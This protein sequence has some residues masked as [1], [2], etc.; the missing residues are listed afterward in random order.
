V[1]RIESEYT[2]W[3]TPARYSGAFFLW[4]SSNLADGTV[5]GAGVGAGVSTCNRAHFPP[6]RPPCIAQEEMQDDRGTHVALG[7]A[8]AI[9]GT[10]N[11]GWQ[12]HCTGTVRARRSRVKDDVSDAKNCTFY[13]R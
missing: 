3:G 13:L 10:L 7:G 8:R 11:H 5:V 6:P 1:L 4:R 2:S 9:V 12:L